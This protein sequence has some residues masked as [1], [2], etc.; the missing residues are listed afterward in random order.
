M[1]KRKARQGVAAPHAKPQR[2][3]SAAAR[4]K[5]RMAAFQLTTL[6]PGLLAAC[7]E[8]ALPDKLGNDV[9]KSLRRCR[10]IRSLSISRFPSSVAEAAWIGLELGLGLGLG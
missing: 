7:H 3:T 2:A 10:P 1:S 9:A 8:V 6:R 5:P 4:S